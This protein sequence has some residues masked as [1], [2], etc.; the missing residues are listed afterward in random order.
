MQPGRQ[1]VVHF[2]IVRLTPSNIRSGVYS[3]PHQGYH[4]TSNAPDLRNPAEYFALS[5][6]KF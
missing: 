2:A 6:Q 3:C 5:P 1:D 4:A